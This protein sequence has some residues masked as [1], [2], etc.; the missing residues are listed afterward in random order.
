ME[1][2]AAGTHGL[3]ARSEKFGNQLA[4]LVCGNGLRTIRF[5]GSVTEAIPVGCYPIKSLAQYSTP[6][7]KWPRRSCCQRGGTIF[8]L[9]TWE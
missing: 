9:I 8:Y 4:R 6:A 5:L 1:K 2:L 7:C 3:F